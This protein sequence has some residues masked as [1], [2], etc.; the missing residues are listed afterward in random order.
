MKLPHKRIRPDLPNGMRIGERFLLSFDDPELEAPPYQ[1]RLQDLSK[2][3]LLCIDAPLDLRPPRGTAVTLHT[4]R[5]GSEDY[6]FAS[7]IQGRGRLKGRLPVLLLRPPLRLEQKRRRSAYRISVCL[8]AEIECLDPTDGDGRLIRKPCVATNLSGGGAQ[9]FARYSPRTQDMRLALTVPSSFVEEVVRS[10]RGTV[11]IN[12]QRTLA[13]DPFLRTRQRLQERLAG[14][15]AQIVSSH[16]HMKDRRGT[17]TALSL[18][19]AEPQETCYQLVRHLERQ[20]IKKGVS[21]TE[22]VPEEG[23][24]VSLELATRNR[25][26]SAMATVAPAA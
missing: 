18:S 17:I 1:G 10:R 21:T 2:D 12:D 14:I 25:G 24:T 6:S 11:R 5:S 20:S 23:G 4:L 22:A 3:G 13:L 16:V 8:R 7:E 15:E 19:F 26:R 9:V